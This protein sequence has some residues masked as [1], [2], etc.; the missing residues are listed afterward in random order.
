MA[1]AFARISVNWRLLFSDEEEIMGF[2]V[3][4]VGATGLVGNALLGLLCEDATITKVHVLVRRPIAEEQRINSAKLVQH[5][6]DF[7]HLAEIEWP[8]C[9]ILFCCLGTTIKVAGSQ[10]AFRKVDFDYVVTA[11]RRARENG[12][13]RFAVVS[14][15]GAKRNSPVFYNRVKGEMEAAVTA[16]NF[17][18]L[19]ILR[20]SILAGERAQ[21]RPGERFA[22]AFLKVGNL[23]LPK[24][25]Q[26]VSATAVARA[27]LKTA[28][29][30]VSGVRVIE[31][32][33]IQNFK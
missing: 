24:K 32:D 30:S 23:L 8:T 27:M 5:V 22:L 25:Y 13:S 6:I 1:A 16:L 26:S 12:A 11:A 17:P 29:D 4:V 19:L 21:P 28:T 15:M 10:A 7:D 2:C 33:Q 20:P 14:S 18:S 31:S 3:C 9:D